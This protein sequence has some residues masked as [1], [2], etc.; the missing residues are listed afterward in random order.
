MSHHVWAVA[1]PGHDPLR[2]ASASYAIFHAHR[3]RILNRGLD[4]LRIAL[5]VAA[6]RSPDLL[7]RL[8]GPSLPSCPGRGCQKRLHK[9]DGFA[10]HR[11]YC[12]DSGKL[13][14]IGLELGWHVLLGEADAL[15]LDRAPLSDVASSFAPPNGGPWRPP[16]STPCGPSGAWDGGQNNTR[17][18]T[19]LKRVLL[20]LVSSGLLLHASVNQSVLGAAGRSLLRFAAHNR[21]LA[22][23][24]KRRGAES[25][26]P[27]SQWESEE[28]HL[29][30][31]MTGWRPTA[32]AV[33][34][35]PSARPDRD[36]PIIR[37]KASLPTAAA[38]N[39]TG[40][41]ANGDN[42][43]QVAQTQCCRWAAPNQRQPRHTT[44]GEP[45]EPDHGWWR[46]LPAN[47]SRHVLLVR[48]NH[49]S[50]GF[51]AYMLFA[52]NQLDFA[53]RR[54]LI[55]YI[56]FGA[57]NV[58]GHDHYA[59]GGANLYYDPA[60][61]PNMWEYYFEPVSSYRP[62]SS[63]YETH[64]LP[65]KLLWRLHHKEASSVFA[66]YYGVHGSKRGYD[67]A[68][69]GAMR[70]RA[71]QLLGRFVRP[72]QHVL[73]AVDAFWTSNFGPGATVLGVHMRGTD[74]QADIG[75][76]IVP[77]QVYMHHIDAYL[78]EHPHARLL[79]ATDSPRFLRRM[80]ERY[81]TKLVARNVLRSERNAFLD[82][83]PAGANER[84]GFDVLV[85]ALL[86]SRCN[87]LLKSSSAVGEFA[88]YFNLS[89]HSR[90]LDLQ[91]VGVNGSARHGLPRSEDPAAAKSSQ[92]EHRFAPCTAAHVLAR[93]TDVCSTF[94]RCTERRASRP[95]AC[96]VTKVALRRAQAL[97][98][99]F[100]LAYQNLLSGSVRS[101]PDLAKV[102]PF[103]RSAAFRSSRAVDLVVSR[104]GEPVLD[105]LVQLLSFLA[106]SINLVVQERCV[107]HTGTEPS[108]WPSIDVRDELFGIQRVAVA[109]GSIPCAAHAEW[110]GQARLGRAPVT[111]CLHARGL[112][113]LAESRVALSCIA[114]ALSAPS[115]A[116]GLQDL[117]R[118]A[119][120]TLLAHTGANDMTWSFAQL[121]ANMSVSIHDGAARSGDVFTLVVSRDELLAHCSSSQGHA[122]ESPLI[123]PDAISRLVGRL[124]TTVDGAL[125]APSV[126]A[127][128]G[129]GGGSSVAKT[130][131][132]IQAAPA[133]SEPN[134]MLFN[135]E[136]W[137]VELHGSV[138]ACSW[139]VEERD[140][141]A[142]LQQS[143]GPSDLRHGGLQMC[144][145]EGVVQTTLLPAGWWSTVLGALKPL[146]HAVRTSRTLLTPRVPAFVDPSLCPR[147]DLSCFFLP[148][149]P[150]C[151]N[152]HQNGTV[153]SV[154]VRPASHP[155]R[156]W[157]GWAGR[158]LRFVGPSRQ[159]HHAASPLLLDL[160]D[161]AFVQAE[162]VTSIPQPFRQRGWFW[163]TSQLLRYATRPS[164]SLQRD[165]ARKAEQSGLSKMLASGVRV[166]GVHIR[167]GDSCS[168]RERRRM[169]R[170]CSPLEDYLEHVRALARRLDTTTVFLATDDASVLEMARALPDL[171]ILA[172]PNASRSEETG[173]RPELWDKLV[174]RRAASQLSH[175]NQQEAWDATIDAMLLARCDALVGKFTSTLF[176][177]A[178]SLKSAT[179]SCVP[180]FVSL[181]APWCFDYGVKA[182]SNWEFPLAST[183]KSTGKAENRFWC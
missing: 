155:R 21:T 123:P 75:G 127:T 181:D 146:G 44:C 178:M 11:L 136:Y 33:S 24:S 1:L 143:Q 79:L 148:L 109:E 83:Q 140:L 35:Y 38:P 43:S 19:R 182:G 128:A 145:S 173:A 180:P 60:S 73:Q 142:K 58:N 90:S 27:L 48:M 95:E 66:Y 7:A 183:H 144:S 4:A 176:R 72:R 139:E 107:G 112:F 22:R 103:L 114:E 3:D 160:H 37:R 8:C 131:M 30:S 81:S 18:T 149:A 168:I 2:A 108:L 147:A 80:R 113:E 49:G 68:W 133:C 77:P 47:R 134:F 171:T 13:A 99:A 162:S 94:V 61:G 28:T 70:T 57:C 20:R 15:P 179:C 110:V 102:Q 157:L 164:E 119:R 41:A 152:F 87:F 167:H 170:T 17:M 172:V 151:D 12:N 116:T 158:F 51:F 26:S 29:L 25:K 23:R 174:T 46:S 56:D 137:P 106:T 50:A 163:W 161:K 101:T 89:L 156:S 150:T 175:L 32:D 86:L 6:M 34:T 59:S 16:L 10:R 55:P 14:G 65:S 71:S 130:T 40:D 96:G 159:L 76:E 124:M 69:Y 64:A 62:G 67:E 91:Y 52:L 125:L 84:K 5:D 74:K 63:G 122:P 36:R 98:G 126:S 135:R 115:T 54:G 88:I 169:A 53:L 117:A 141:S 121:P 105:F 166:I 100:R 154:E 132:T 9:E 129:A 93:H 85:D 177:T 97:Y 82:V 120:S 138:P 78:Q 165:L 45:D 92:H 153:A 111:L 31:T 39:A 118:M 104:C 42:V